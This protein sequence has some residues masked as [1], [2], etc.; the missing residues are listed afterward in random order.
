M[1]K[2]GEMKP[3]YRL[4]PLLVGSSLVP[5]GLLWYGWTVGKAHWIV[6]II[7]TMFI[8]V[9]MITVFMPVN[10]YLVD[11]FTT[12]AASATAANTVLRSLGG[13][14]LPL[15]GRRMYDALGIGWGNAL[16]AFVALGLI[17]VIWC[18]LKYGEMIRTHPRFRLDL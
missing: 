15:C 11:A 6:P 14:L 2:G 17:P 1:A 13:A 7:G 12:Y 9:G 18:F 10:T 8:G 3:E 5:I 16:L 4:L